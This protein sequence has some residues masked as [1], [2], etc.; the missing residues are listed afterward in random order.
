MIDQ[1]AIGALLLVLTTIVHATCMIISLRTIRV[2][3]AERWRLHWL[4]TSTILTA[5]LVLMM[6]SASILEAWLY[7]V[8]YVNVGAIGG[9]EPAMYFSIVTF[10]TLG[11]GDVLVAEQWRILA[12]TEAANGIIMFGWTTALI[13]YFVGQLRSRKH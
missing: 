3:R 4:L 13:V 9:F 6:F 12:A 8:T 5:A 11:Y 2:L 7:A 10:T 1:L